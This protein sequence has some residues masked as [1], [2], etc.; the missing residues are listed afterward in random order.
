MKIKPGCK[1]FLM[2]RV[3]PD[4]I[5]LEFNHGQMELK[6]MLLLETKSKQ[7][8]IK[9]DVQWTSAAYIKVHVYCGLYI[10]YTKH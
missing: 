10:Y 6:C 8:V 1:Y 3:D 4:G 2:T 9:I 5:S 7:L